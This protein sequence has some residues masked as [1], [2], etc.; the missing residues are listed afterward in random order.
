MR[1]FLKK[2]LIHPGNKRINRLFRDFIKFSCVIFDFFG[3]I[4]FSPFILFYG[5]DGFSQ[6]KVKKI[7]L[8]RID[9]IG[10]LILS[11]PAI[12]AV[13]QRFKDARI[14]ILI[15]E[16]TK[17]IVVNNP[18]VDKVLIYQKDMIEDDYDLAIS[19]HPGLESNYLTFKSGAKERIGYFGAGGGFFLT[20]G[21]KD[22]RDI[23]VRHE[24]ES[25]L[26]LVSMAGC[27]SLDKSLDVS[28]TMAGEKAAEEFI[29]KN[30]LSVLDKII[31]IHP[32]AN[33]EYIRWRKEGFAQVARRLVDL[34]G[35]NVILLGSES[36]RALVD[37]VEDLS[38]R[39]MIISVGLSLTATISLIKRATLFIGNSTGPMHIAAGLGV[40]VVAVFGSSHLLD[41]YKE[42]G[43]WSKKN[44][45]VTRNLDCLNCHPSDCKD[46]HCMDAVTPEDVLSAAGKLLDSD[47]NAEIQEVWVLP[48]QPEFDKSS[49]GL[50]EIYNRHIREQGEQVHIDNF[51]ELKQPSMK[52]R[53]EEVIKRLDPRPG[54]RILD[55]GCG[56][57]T[58]AYHSA[59]AG[60]IVFGID[61]SSES[62]ASAKRFSE[63]Y[64]VGSP[65]NFV[66]G[67]AAK[68][69][70]D[71]CSFD[72]I[73]LADFIEH[74]LNKEKE[75]ALS[76]IKRVLKPGGT[77]VIF[78][79]NAVREQIA[80]YY[81][82][83]RRLFFKEPIPFNELHIGLTGK[84]EFESILKAQMWAFKL[85]YVDTTRP[86]LA[87]IP[88]VRR[89]LALQLLWTVKK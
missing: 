48:P 65:E 38:Q 58:F 56:V 29:S 3:G 54:E 62:I 7:L 70:F 72:K 25:A 80:V 41:S 37:Q 82:W 14:D 60:A 63:K 61:Y 26:E 16:Y 27:A 28:I 81:H 4:L 22:D 89:L 73:V 6:D 32:G 67:S 44:I 43:P 1:D 18:N 23:R 84:E 5:R 75:Q 8:I 88:L 55:V 30:K 24:V 87:K 45:V 59:K 13:R 17:D 36:E 50:V 40:P 69:P 53:V 79:P 49:R 31:I 64:K 21:V 83:V 71:D 10:D 15:K 47:K 66:L 78:T 68:L 19:F 42:W 57:G 2:A 34:G 35:F 51:Y 74:I 52:R 33:Q 76:E 11:T 46:F 9:R 77:A 86:Y 12:K 20:R 39:K 85:E